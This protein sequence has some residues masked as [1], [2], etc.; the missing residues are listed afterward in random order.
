MSVAVDLAAHAMVDVPGPRPNTLA[1][2]FDAL[3]E[4]RLIDR[5][6]ATRLS[7]MARFRN[8]LVCRCGEQPVLARGARLA[9]P[10]ARR[11]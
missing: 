5:P 4:R 9:A 2:L 11:A 6:L 1:G 10:R 7:A 3:A 8:L